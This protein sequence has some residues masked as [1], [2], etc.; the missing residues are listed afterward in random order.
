MTSAV[1]AALAPFALAAVL[2]CSPFPPA[3][4]QPDPSKPVHIIVPFPAAG[5]VDAT[6]RILGERPWARWGQPVIVD[7]RPGAASNIGA[8]AAYRAEPDGTTT[9][10]AAQMLAAMAGLEL[11]HIP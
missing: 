11:V 2:L 4:A 8:A 6:T 5:A 7:S 9:G 10:L 3:L 1:R